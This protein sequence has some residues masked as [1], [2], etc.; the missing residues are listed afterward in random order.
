MLEG[1]VTGFERVVSGSNSRAVVA[2][3]LRLLANGR[4]LVGKRYQA[5]HPAADESLGAFAVAM[6]QALGRIYAEFLDDV[7]RGR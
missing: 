6:E 5:E 4:Q 3:E 2:L 7:A 1:R